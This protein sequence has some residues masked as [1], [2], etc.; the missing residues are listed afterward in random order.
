MSELLCIA[1]NAKGAGA[2]ELVVAVAAAQQADAQ[3]ASSPRGEQIPDRIADDVA[4]L[5]WNA[6]PFA[7]GEEE[8]GLRLG[9]KHVTSLDD[10]GLGSDPESV[11]RGV[12]LGPPTGCRDSVR[13]ADFTQFGEQLDGSRQRPPLGE[14]LTEELTMASLNR[15]YLLGGERSAELPV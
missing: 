12:D 2:C 11:Q 9:P 8:I 1:V 4:L 13:D 10:D 15:F 3:H 7:A 14:Q 6:D 5:G